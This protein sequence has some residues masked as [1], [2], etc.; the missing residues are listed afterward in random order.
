VRKA[1]T[2]IRGL[3]PRQSTRLLPCLCQE[4]T[5]RS[6]RNLRRRAECAWR[7]PVAMVYVAA[8]GVP[9]VSLQHLLQPLGDGPGARDLRNYNA[10]PTSTHHFHGR[11]FSRY[12][13]VVRNVVC[14]Y[15]DRRD[16]RIISTSNRY[17]GGQQSWTPSPCTGADGALGHRCA[18]LGPSPHTSS[19]SRTRRLRAPVQVDAQTPASMQWLCVT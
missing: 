19:T 2:Y 11:C 16:H 10:A 3:Y 8:P 13:K 7:D 9:A 17:R 1:D 14:R 5:I 12:V 15:R 18:R 4:Y 6:P